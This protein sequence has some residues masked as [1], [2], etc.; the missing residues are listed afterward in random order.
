MNAILDLGKW[1]FALPFAVFGVRH[2][3]YAD[4]MSGWTPGGAVMVYVTGACLIAATVSIIIGKYDKLATILL[5]V[6]LLAF[7]GI[8]HFPAAMKGD[9][10][11]LLKDI[12][13]AGAA[14]IYAKTMAKDNSV[15]G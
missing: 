1:L 7:V 15:V 6:M 3:M 12:S 14:L 10:T 8:L 5:A 4:M 2:F 13:L 9:W 11:S